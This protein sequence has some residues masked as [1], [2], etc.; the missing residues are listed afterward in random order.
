MSWW[1]SIIIFVNK[2]FAVFVNI[3]LIIL[4]LRRSNTFS[5][6]FRINNVIIVGFGKIQTE[7]NYSGTVPLFIKTNKYFENFWR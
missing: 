5:R 2:I 3:G 7:V 4:G 6:V 1:D